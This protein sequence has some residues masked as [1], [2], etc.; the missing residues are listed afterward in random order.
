QDILQI[1]YKK[2]DFYSAIEKDKLAVLL[3]LEGLSGIGED[4][5]LIYSLYHLGFRL[6]SLTWNEQNHLAT[7]AGGD[8]N[9]GLTDL[10][11]KAIKIINEL[12]IILDVSHAND[13]SFWDIAN[14]AS[15][16]FIASH[17]NSRAICN[18]P[19]NLTDEQIK[20]IG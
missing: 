16:P 10:G 5:D 6:M 17:S 7:G 1:M 15:K 18:V 4:V 3:G 13:K 12:G 14:T 2:D 19:R 20:F 9:R 11:K 8:I